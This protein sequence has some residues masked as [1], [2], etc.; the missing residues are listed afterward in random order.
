MSYDVSTIDTASFKMLSP[1]T[2][3]F[4]TGSTSK[5][6]KIA[7]VATGSTAEINDPNAKLS[8]KSNL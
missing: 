7:K 1:K 3:M 2:N 6:L 5:A 4:N 8:T